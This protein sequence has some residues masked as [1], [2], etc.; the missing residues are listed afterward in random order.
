MK[1]INQSNSISNTCKLKHMHKK[2]NKLNISKIKGGREWLKKFQI[3]TEQRRVYQN[4]KEKNARRLYKAV[5]VVIYKS[6]KQK[7]INQ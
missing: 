3:F 1:H 5:R 6:V 7:N 4:C 2:L